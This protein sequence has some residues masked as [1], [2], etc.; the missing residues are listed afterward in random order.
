MIFALLSLLLNPIFVSIRFIVPSIKS[1]IC[2]KNKVFLSSK[3]KPM[4]SSNCSMLLLSSS[5]E[6]EN[7]SSNFKF[8]VFIPSN[9]FAILGDN[10]FLRPS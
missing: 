10:K 3:I 1:D 4:A 8:N 2:F 6:E 7:N 5:P 9:L